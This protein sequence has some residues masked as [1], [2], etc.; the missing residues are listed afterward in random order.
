MRLS[1]LHLER[2]GRFEDHKL[3]FPA[4][5]RDFHLIYG[6]NEAGKSTTLAAI[7]DL[8]FGFEHAV[9]QDYRFAAGLL[10]VG[11]VL[12]EGDQ[13]L[14]CRRRRGRQGTLIDLADQP[15]DEGALFAMLHGQGRDAF[16]V[17]SSL[18]HTR[19]R[20][21]GQA[22]AESKDDL[23]Q[24]LFAAGSGLTGV[25]SVLAGLDGEL[26]EIWGPRR[27]DKRSFTRA[28]RTAT[29]AR[30][31]LRDAA[32]K[33]AE[34]VKARDACEQLRTDHHAAEAARSEAVAGLAAVERLRR[35]LTPLARRSTLLGE[36]NSDTSTAVPEAV[37]A[38]AREALR[39][40][41]AQT[42]ARDAARALLT[43]V[44]RRLEAEPA[45]TETLAFAARIDALVQMVGAEADR[46]EQTPRRVRELQVRRTAAEA[47]A[48]RLGLVIDERLEVALP[49]EAEITRLR[50]LASRRVQLL[51]VQETAVMTAKAAR[52]DLD[53]AIAARAAL[54]APESLDALQSAVVSARRAGDLD[55]QAAERAATQ[56]RAQTRLSEALAALAPWSGDIN[57]LARL[58]PPSDALLDKA[59]FELDQADRDVADARRLAGE[60]AE[61]LAL[62]EAR[63]A[64]LS[65]GGAAI[66]LERLDH[67]RKARDEVVAALGGHLKGDAPIANP[68][69]VL[70][71]LEAVIASA[72]DLADRR[73]AAA[74]ASARLAQ[75]EL[76]MTE[77]RLRHVQAQA[78]VTAA[79]AEG[80]ERMAAWRDELGGGNLPLLAPEDLRAWLGRRARALER[81]DECE[82]AD[83]AVRSLTVQRISIGKALAGVLGSPA[84]AEEALAPLLAL[85][86]GRLTSLEGQARAIL[87]A[88]R[89]RQAAEQR[90]EVA[91]AACDRAKRELTAWSTAWDAALSEAGLALSPEAAETRL[92]VFETLRGELDQARG[93][94]RRID[95]MANDA[96][97]FQAEAAAVSSALQMT[98]ETDAIEQVRK[99]KARLEIAQAIQARH[100]ALK[101]EE[102]ARHDEIDE[103]QARL[104]AAEAALFDVKA[105]T[106]LSEHVAL[107][108]ALDAARGRRER[109]AQLGDL[110]REI[111]EHGD[112]RPLAELE[113]SCAG[114]TAEGLA[115]RAAELAH[116][117]E[118][119]AT[120]AGALGKARAE[121]DLRFQQL[122]AGPA[123]ADAAAEVE[124]ARAEME[125]LAEVYILKRIQRVLLDHAVR[126]Q[127]AQRRNPLLARASTL[128][129][130]L[131]RGGY[132]ELRADHEAD[133]PR[134][135][136]L[137]ADAETV[138]PV[139]LMS[140]G[141][142]DQLFL[143]LR[144]AAVEQ[145]HRAG[146]RGPFLADDLFMTFDDD[147][148]RAGLQVLGELSRS[149]QVLFFTHH[150]H[151]RALAAEVFGDGLSRLELSE[152]T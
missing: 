86:E 30:G 81:R 42:Q 6:P 53:R 99:A 27:S 130:A 17:A 14:T 103:A 7:S 84:P 133:R 136:G 29:E 1:E 85:A 41:S 95:T 45:D 122:D 102:A 137:K 15:L 91:D 128:F 60:R 140:E 145:S 33:P 4:A 92:G 51:A 151:L 10:R 131:T 66:S 93:L 143:A 35:V 120:E 146:V 150:D 43:A 48:R 116:A 124:H 38:A 67:A 26:D 109:E 18:D 5:E 78:R 31:A 68:A 144:L 25:R 74:D 148:A 111:A 129:Q 11:A 3:S 9:A 105:L 16:L 126:W 152:V 75:A 90:H 70:D 47:A 139:S 107:A 114:E 54:Q 61:A 13:R 65:A 94:K 57:A 21:G 79:T 55:G 123:A 8:L 39:T 88:E 149:T 72:D 22:M 24:M 98:D 49:T 20:R 138:V 59:K 77:Q 100:L 117:A 28:E 96:D 63:L 106:G 82:A 83:A 19:L 108:G 23:G 113:A 132:S 64:A 121:A 40:V 125:A 37:E 134:L 58:A 50:E 80:V 56:A 62:A 104:A 46:R 101:E 135:L 36:L 115:A 73:F 127:A 76:E 147:R 141:T 89:E 71:Q 112:G 97:A 69:Q 142:Q 34:W 2:Y 32:V 12:E 87:D 110:E 119:A 52:S 118:G 44:S